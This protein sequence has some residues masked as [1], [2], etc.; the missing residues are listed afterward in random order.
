MKKLSPTP[1]NY[2]VFVSFSDL[3][4][5]EE[6]PSVIDIIRHYPRSTIIQVVCTLGQFYGEGEIERYKLFFSPEN[7]HQYL[8]IEKRFNR[9]L[10]R[11]VFP[12]AKYYFSSFVT[13]LELLRYS[14][15]L[16]LATD[17]DTLP[18]EEYE[19]QLFRA[20]LIINQN[21]ICRFKSKKDL[22]KYQLV[23]LNNLCYVDIG[24][25]LDTLLFQQL[26]YSYFF[27]TFL[28]KNHEKT[29]ALLEAFQNHYSATW[30]Q[31]VLIIVSLFILLKKE[32]TG[33]LN[34]DLTLDKTGT[35]KK[36]VLDKISMSTTSIFKYSSDNKDD[37]LGNS[38][39]RYFREFPLI[40]EEDSYVLYSP[41]IV[42][43]KLYNSL[44]FDFV[45]INQALPQKQRIGNVHQL[46][47]EDYIQNHLLVQFTKS[48]CLNRYQLCT[49]LSMTCNYPKKKDNELGP[50]DLLLKAH[51]YVVLF[52]CK[53]IRL[54]GWIKEQKDYELII[55]ELEGKIIGLQDNHK[56]IGQLAGHLKS[57]REGH[58]P[59]ERISPG[60]KVY[61]VLILSDPNII[62]EGLYGIVSDRYEETL[63]NNHIRR[64][65][66]NR[67]LVLMS[68][69]TLYKYSNLFQ[70]KGFAYY[71]EH[72]YSFLKVTGEK[73]VSF[74]Q[75]MG[76]QSF[77][78]KKQVGI[79]LADLK[80][81]NSLPAIS[82]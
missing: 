68:V 9:F 57:I 79:I 30:R 17:E 14:F 42:L 60:K 82:G 76:W 22:N 25:D 67:P 51:K 20:L 53:D 56:G 21:T 6:V 24:K 61:P 2:H 59:W 29:H 70:K 37:R 69:F 77:N 38:D 28:E 1:Y 52:E 32:G 26:V 15:S 54:N 34:K 7:H 10:S 65:A 39:Y 43:G 19:W 72:Y 49:E 23:Y 55:Q 40:D 18:I 64:I 50:P 12:N 44:F 62:Q 8:E 4:P 27:F 71:F 75:Y 3:F 41:S 63:H 36:S 81:H 35:L 46:F 33:K 13:G 48:I 31:Y 73:E 58:F 47:Q 45:T 78:M 66:A 11:A 80:K 5:E 16:P 74:D